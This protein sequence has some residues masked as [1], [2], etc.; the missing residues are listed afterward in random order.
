[1][2]FNSTHLGHKSNFKWVVNIVIDGLKI[3][4]QLTFSNK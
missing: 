2:N 4:Q 1:L 3:Y